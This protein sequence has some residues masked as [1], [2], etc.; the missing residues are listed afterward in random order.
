MKMSAHSHEPEHENENETD[1]DTGADTDRN[2]KDTD[3]DG[4]H[5]RTTCLSRDTRQ[6]NG[7]GHHVWIIIWT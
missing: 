3:M 2:G 1:T 6:E 4:R 5:A 7:Y